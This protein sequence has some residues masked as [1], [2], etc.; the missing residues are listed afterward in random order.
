MLRAISKNYH[1]L[2]CTLSHD[3]QQRHS[4]QT[5]TGFVLVRAYQ[6]G[7]LRNKYRLQF[8]KRA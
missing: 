7:I 8:F 6:S 3:Q 2:L 1:T 5:T 4:N